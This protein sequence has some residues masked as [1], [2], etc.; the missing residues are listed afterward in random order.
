MFNLPI[1]LQ[2]EILLKTDFETCIKWNYKKG[3]QKF[4]DP[5]IHTW[6]WVAEMVV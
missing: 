4:Y 2:E 3:I 5:K 1:E 6:N